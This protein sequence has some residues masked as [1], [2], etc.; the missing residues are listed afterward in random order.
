MSKILTDKEVLRIVSDAIRKRTLPPKEYERFLRLLGSLVAEHFGG[1]VKSVSAPMGRG[2]SAARF[3]VHFVA[4]D[5]VPKDGGPYARFDTD[6]SV[7]LWKKES[8]RER[9]SR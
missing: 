4:D 2:G 6:V 7:A 5:R 9:R 1:Y 3:C 8:R